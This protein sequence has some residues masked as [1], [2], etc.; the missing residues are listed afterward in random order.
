MALVL[1][2]IGK[3]YLV[4]GAGVAV[5][6]L[7]FGIDRVEP[8][9]R[10][11]WAFRPLILPGLILIWPLVLWRWWA[12]A[13]GWD[14]QRRHLPPRRAQERLG[15]ALAVAIPLVLAIAFSVK[16]GEPQGQ[17]AIRLSTPGEVSR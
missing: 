9:A 10:G 6:F 17:P 3:A 7:A 13:R 2:A 14:E 16:Q 1:L 8:N 4:L 12:L 15:L 5:V 11:A